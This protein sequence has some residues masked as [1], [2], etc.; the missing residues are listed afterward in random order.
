[1]N[2]Y[3]I[4]NFIVV[5]LLIEGGR[6]ESGLLKGAVMATDA[7]TFANLTSLIGSAQPICRPTFLTAL[8]AVF[9]LLENRLAIAANF[10][11]VA[12]AAASFAPSRQENAST[13]E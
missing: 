1:M 6:P 5:A 7:A 4:G 3:A 10:Q 11:S 13:S 2:T 9:S 12:R 8:I